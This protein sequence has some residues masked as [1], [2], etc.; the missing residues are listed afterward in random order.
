[1]NNASVT[2]YIRSIRSKSIVGEGIA[3]VGTNSCQLYAKFAI[4]AATGP[5]TVN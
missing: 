1:M 5:Q 4:A 2:L 3:S